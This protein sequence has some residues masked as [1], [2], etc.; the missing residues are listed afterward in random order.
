MPRWSAP[1][2]P[3]VPATANV[4]S[5]TG[6][7][8]DDATYWTFD[9]AVQILPGAGIETWSLFTLV[10]DGGGGACFGVAGVQTS[11]TVIRVMMNVTPVDS[12][13]GWFWSLTEV[14]LKVKTVSGGDVVPGGGDFVSE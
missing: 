12:G 6:S 10:E 4:I 2:S 8:G 5:V 7:Y 14:P 13:N 3:P 9:Q 11:P 1:A